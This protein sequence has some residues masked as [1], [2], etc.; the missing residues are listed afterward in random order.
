MKKTKRKNLIS[1][2]FGLCPVRHIL[3]GVF[4]LLVGA[5]LLLRRNR[6]I[7][8]AVTFGAVRPYHR[9]AA[10]LFSKVPFSVAELIEAAAIIVVLVYIII[11]V[12]NIIR[13]PERLK[14]VY[15]TLATLAVFALGIYAA[16][17]WLLG[18]CYYADNFSDQSGLKAE[19]VSTE[20]LIEV[21]EYFAQQ[22]NFYSALVQRDEQGIFTCDEDGLFIRN[23]L[24]Y[25]SI[26]EEFP[27]L[28]SV[29]IKTKPMFFSRIM[30]MT[31]FTGVFFP[32]TGEANVNVDSPL[33]YRPSTIAHEMAHQ[34]GVASESEANFVAV[35]ACMSS[36]DY[37]FCYSG[38]LLAYTHLG[39][40]LYTAN[41]DAWREIY[42]TLNDDVLRDFAANRA[43]W[44]QFE[45]PLSDA[46]E[47]AYDGFLRSNGFDGMR[48]YGACVD[49]LVAYYKDKI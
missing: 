26:S 30:S 2:W 29:Y 21:T 33:C 6:G 32:F 25:D 7:M 24:L 19:P 17:S 43:Y 39:N 48:S 35:A 4:A 3:L 1:E 37:D 15:I 40:A 14:R 10:K 38:A 49:L 8:N 23:E 11:Q 41:Y 9:F 44:K 47:G 18:V 27:C 28:E 42:A 20:E 34:R 22:A 31:G 13:K 36:G 5:Y 45:S 46:A 16:L 12:V